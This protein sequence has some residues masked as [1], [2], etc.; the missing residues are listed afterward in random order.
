MGRRHPSTPV[1][2]AQWASQLLANQGHYGLVSQIAREGGVSRQT[3]YRWKAQGRLALLDCFSRAPSATAVSPDLVC[4]ILSC[5]IGF[6]TARGIQ[7]TLRNLTAQ[8]I[9]LST[10]TAVLQEAEQRALS[11]LRGPI[12]PL[13]RPL[14]LDEMFGQDHEHAY[15]HVVDAQGGAVWAAEGP[16]APDTQSWSLVLMQLQD[17]NLYWDR[18]VGDQGLALQ[19]AYRSLT[20]DGVFQ[21][22]LWHEQHRGV[23]LQAQLER[24]YRQLRDKSAVVSRQAQRIAKGERPRGRNPSSDVDAHALQLQQARALADN[25]DFLRTQLRR[26]WE[27]VVEGT[28]QLLSR[29]TREAEIEAAL[30][31][32]L[33]LAEQAPSKHQSEFKQLHRNWSEVRYE[34]LTFVEQ[35]ERV[36][37]DLLNQVGQAEQALLGWAWLRRRQLG[38]SSTQ[39]VER[40]PEEWR[41]AARVLLQTWDQAI[42]VSTPVE[43]WHSI[44]RPHLTVHRTLSVGRL[45]LLAVW[46]NH[47][48]FTRGVN[49]GK[50]PLQLSGVADAP[51]DWLVALGYRD[52][53]AQPS[54]PPPL[55]VALLRAA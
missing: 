30:Q 25:L 37:Q 7:T 45:A 8:G 34:L 46:H 43:R 22:D 9:S 36:Q 51:T 5:F 13:K 3:L 11:L 6:G 15:L 48:V 49:K 54:Q 32:L 2:Q 41:A 4:Q 47:R 23:R 33:E 19:A 52:A 21:R 55:A 14:A 27:V 18:A 31:L 38:W 20:P 42:R 39:I 12:K 35:I 16:L 44:L 24:T 40:L 29:E 1:Q 53:D 50:N 17:R 10:I 28:G 26:L